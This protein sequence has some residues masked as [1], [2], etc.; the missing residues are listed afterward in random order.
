MATTTHSIVRE[1]VHRFDKIICIASLQRRC[2]VVASEEADQEYRDL[3]QAH[4]GTIGK[5]NKVG[6]T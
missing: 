5:E 6:R 2:D 4:F 3:D 1:T